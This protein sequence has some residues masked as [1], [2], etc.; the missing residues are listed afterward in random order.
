MEAMITRKFDHGVTG[1][2]FPDEYPINPREDDNLGTMVCWHNRYTLGDEQ[3]DCSPDEYELPEDCI[4]LPLYL[5]DHSGVTMSTKPFSC[6]WDSGQ[7]GFIFCKKGAEGMSDEQIERCLEG[8]VETY[9]DLITGQVYEYVIEDKDGVVLDSCWGFF[10]DT[11][12]IESEMK[13][14][15]ELHA[16]DEGEKA[17]EAKMELVMVPY[18]E[19]NE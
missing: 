11:D 10:G 19:V 3:P 16:L 1:E 15:G 5:Y 9:N 18:E 14:L 17:K 4:K 6:P 2:I 12:Y 8:E 7:V 13:N